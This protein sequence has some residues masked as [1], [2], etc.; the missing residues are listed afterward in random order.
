MILFGP[1]ARVPRDSLVKA[2]AALFPESV[3]GAIGDPSDEPEPLHRE[4]LAF[5]STAVPSR[6]QEF[7]CGR[8]CA[9]LALGLLGFQ[10]VT[11]PVGP[12]RGPRWPEGVVGSITHC[13]GLVGAVV[14]LESHT[15]GIGFD[16]VPVGRP[17]DGVVNLVCTDAELAW[18][19]RASP[20]GF[21]GWPMV[22]FSAKEAIHKC[23]SPLTGVMLDFR[24]V[25]V[26]LDRDRRTFSA[27][28]ECG[29][30][31]LEPYL[32]AISGRYV[33][34]RTHVIAAGFLD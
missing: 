23:L 2:I 22:I 25:T 8:A 19:E 13:E 18:I 24:D 12:R 9:R 10:N 15:R 14:C 30:M 17:E 4:E 34:T 20:D 6:Q 1:G 5:V 31:A 29:R 7:A 26:T 16:A 11:I 3:C 21:P 32:A 33:V 27:R 28:L